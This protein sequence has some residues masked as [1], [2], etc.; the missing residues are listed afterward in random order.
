MLSQPE[1]LLKITWSM[2]ALYPCALRAIPVRIE[3]HLGHL[4]CGLT[5]M[6]PQPNSQPG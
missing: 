3:P 6:P 4:R 2:M 1:S 5:D